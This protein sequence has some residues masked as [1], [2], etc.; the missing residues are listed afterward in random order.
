MKCCINIKFWAICSKNIGSHL[1][2]CHWFIFR[3]RLKHH[4]KHFDS[5]F[6]QMK[7]IQKYKQNAHEVQHFTSITLKNIRMPD[8][9]KR[10][11]PIVWVGLVFFQ[12][13]LE[14]FVLFK[15]GNDQDWKWEDTYS[16]RPLPSVQACFPLHL[17]HRALIYGTRLQIAPFWI[18]APWKGSLYEAHALYKNIWQAERN[19]KQAWVNE[20]CSLCIKEYFVCNGIKNMDGV[21]FGHN[22]G[23]RTGLPIRIC[24]CALQLWWSLLV[25]C[26]EYFRNWKIIFII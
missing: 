8:I 4:Q 13:D 14:I 5:C 23:T 7:T 15:E 24:L 21:D 10:K 1:A 12:I 25:F 18:F 26:N 6:L 20:K 2:Q 16:D 11:D 17:K 22:R 9:V 19:L 3:R